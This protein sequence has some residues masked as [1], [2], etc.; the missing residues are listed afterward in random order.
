MQGALPTNYAPNLPTII[1]LSINVAQSYPNLK[2]HNYCSV[3]TVNLGLQRSGTS[4]STEILSLYT[5]VAITI[6][7]VVTRC[8]KRPEKSFQYKP[9]FVNITVRDSYGLLD[10]KLSLYRS[11]TIHPQKSFAMNRIRYNRG[12]P[13]ERSCV[14]SRISLYHGSL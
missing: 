6:I 8:W 12:R 1:A 14:T 2:H 3:L 7:E 4:T 13:P 11:G 5:E 10:S 9:N